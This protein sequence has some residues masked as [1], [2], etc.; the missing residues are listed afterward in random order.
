[1]DLRKKKFGFLSILDVYI[2]KKLLLTFF[3]AI[4]LI[5]MIAIIF[6]LSERLDDFISNN[7]PIKGLIFDYYLNFIPHFANLFG[8]LFFFI[9]VVGIPLNLAPSSSVMITSCATST[10]LLV[11]YPASAVFNA[12]SAKPF[13]AP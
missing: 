8:H 12:V 1:M 6:D 4:F 11:R 10:D 2:I 5:I 9:A 7:A 13:L 3:L